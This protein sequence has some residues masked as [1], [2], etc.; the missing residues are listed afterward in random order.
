VLTV[1]LLFCFS[2]KISETY[3]AAQGTV[4]FPPEDHVVFLDT[5]GAERSRSWAPTIEA[6]D[7]YL[8]LTQSCLRVIA[9]AASS[10]ATTCDVQGELCCDRTVQQ[11]TRVFSLQSSNVS[12]PDYF[13]TND[14]EEAKVR[15]AAHFRNCSLF[16]IPPSVSNSHLTPQAQS[17]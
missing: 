9:L 6:G 15:V 13:V 11:F 8:R 17:H 4:G 14:A 7:F 16:C 3:W 5:F 12:K 2:C 1:T 10:G